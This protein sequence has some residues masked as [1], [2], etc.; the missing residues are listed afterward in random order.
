MLC[1]EAHQANTRSKSVGEGIQDVDGWI[2]PFRPSLIGTLRLIQPLD[3]LLKDSKNGSGRGAGLQLRGEWMR[4]Q[5]L[6]GAFF[7]GV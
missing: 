6:P 1:P 5:I 4:N 2:K 7:V 3:L